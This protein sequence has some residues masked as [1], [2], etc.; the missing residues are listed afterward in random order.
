MFVFKTM[1]TD[2]IKSSEVKKCNII[3]CIDCGAGEDRYMNIK[4]L[5]HE[6]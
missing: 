3:D 5:E 4:W 6:P 2:P 1:L